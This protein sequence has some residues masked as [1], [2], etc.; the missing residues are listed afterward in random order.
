MDAQDLTTPQRVQWCPGCGNFGLLMAIK[1]AIVNLNLDLNKLCLVSGIGCSGKMPHYMR[2]YGFETLHGRLLPVA[3]SIKLVNPELTVIGSGGDGDGY[4][5]GMGHFMHAMRRNNDIAYIVHNNQVYGLTKGQYSPTSEKGYKSTS[6]PFGALEEPVNPLALAITQGATFVARG[7]AGD[8]KHLTW[9]IEQAI[10]HKGFALVDV[11]Q[12]C[13]T[14]N[15]VNTF[16]Y[17]QKRVYKLQD[18]NHDVANRKLAW[19]K[20]Q[21]W[22][23]RIPTGIFYRE[24]RVLY[25]EQLPQLKLPLPKHDLGKI[26]ITPLLEEH[27]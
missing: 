5:I 8:V 21:E 24:N 6:S 17:F 26:D 10:Q 3:E 11:L 18:E 7:F 12:P 25:E 15:N 9:L 22:G 4:G 14:W 2:T 19:E 16:Q 20:A 27:V 23:D 1:N 13:V